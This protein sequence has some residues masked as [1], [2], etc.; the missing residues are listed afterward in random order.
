G[1]DA[2]KLL[3]YY[4]VDESAEIN[5]QKH[6]FV[7]RVGSECAAED[8]PFFLE[9]VSYD[10]NNNDVNGADYA[11]VKPHK[12]NQAVREFIKPYYAV[13]VLKVESPVNMKFVEGFSS[14]KPVYSQAEAKSYFKEQSDASTLPY[15]FLS[16]GV[17]AE[18]F[19][20]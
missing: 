15:I 4:D 3:L 11:K 14:G 18:L 10:A 13:D 5:G 12:V 19:Q 2:V 1:A 20:E 6:A 9:I 8:V 16:A 17:S 7:E